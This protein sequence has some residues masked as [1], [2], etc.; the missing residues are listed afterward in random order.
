MKRNIF[1]LIGLVF[2]TAIPTAIYAQKTILSGVLMDSLTNVTEPYATIRIVSRQNP[3]TPLAMAITDMQGRFEQELTGKGD[4]NIQ[5]SSVGKTNVTVPFTLKGESKLDLGVI[6]MTE[7]VQTL[8]SVEIVAQRPLV[9]M[10]VDKMSYNI[11]DDVDSRSSTVLDMLRKVPMVT[12]DGEDNITVNG[13]S[14]FKVY[15]DGKPNVMMSSNPSEVFKNMPANVIKNIE[16]ITNP[17]ARYDAE[18]VGGVLNLVTERTASADNNMSG[19]NATLRGMANNRGYG[20]G[21]YI[22]TQ[23]GKLSLSVNGNLMNRKMKDRE[24]EMIRQQTGATDNMTTNYRQT[25]DMDFR[26]RMANVNMGYEI[27]SLRQLNASFGLMGFSTKDHSISQT[28]MKGGFYGN[29][30]HY[31]GKS[32][33]KNDRTSINGS[34]DYQRTFA[35]S[36]NKT[37]TLSYLVSTS[38]NNSDTYNTFIH[39]E[40][41]SLINLTDRYTDGHTN[42]VENTFQ[43]DYST[44][45]AN[46][47]TL[48]AGAKYILR[49]NSSDS[50]YYTGSDD[51]YTYDAGNS[52]NYTHDN[53]IWA[54]YMEYALK[55]K[56]WSAK[57]GFRYEHTWQDVKY[58]SGQ[59]T[60]FKLNYN[61]FVPSGSVSYILG[62]GS[63]IGLTYNMRISRPGI[64]LLNPYVNNS[65]PTAISYGNSGLD[66]EKA[67]NISMVYN[68]FTPK[69]MMNVTLRQ[70]FCNNAIEGYSFYEDNILHS[71]YGNIVKNSQTGLNMY[72]NWNA[73]PKTRFTFNGGISYVDLKSTQLEL[74]NNGWQGNMMLGFQQT[75]PLQ[76]RLSMNLITSGKRYNLQGWNGGFNAV[77]GSLSRT[78]L[79]DKLSVSV[80]GTTSFHKDGNME[81]KSHTHGK[82]FNSRSLMTMPM[83]NIGLSVSYT[84]G[85]KL[86]IRQPK[87]VINN[88]DLKENQSDYDMMENMFIQ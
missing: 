38:P 16:V 4:Y 54:G 44:Q 39:D 69:W 41:N 85:K 27:D 63:N 81:F 87:R 20:G 47:H 71:T 52:M 14:S 65:D 67:H 48:D 43:I 55:A 60:D 80:S 40:D 1:V 62:A 45:I 3:D 17:G 9:R 58:K 73:A 50:K 74:S 83:R 19:Y 6:Y 24:T 75:L 72:I 56:Q 82:D 34:I 26:I 8:Q 5:F 12:V 31:G 18:G 86:T 28:S 64:G 53:D 10:E 7:D 78:F 35:G 46:G 76:I 21:F 13:S 33:T 68:L 11:A 37:L 32:Y 30:F 36:K 42:T 66:P 49:N 23:Q 51:N 22:N 88:S 59:G 57:A 77:M 25:G 70:S 61:N 84:F 2:L 29:G 79:K 15:L